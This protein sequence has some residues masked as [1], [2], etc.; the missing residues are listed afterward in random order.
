MDAI[1]AFVN[2]GPDIGDVV[3]PNLLLASSDR[4][5][6][7]AIGVAILRSYGSTDDVMRGQIFDLDQIKRAAEIGVGVDSA[8]KIN[9][10][11]VNDDAIN[12]VDEIRQILTS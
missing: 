9:L 2:R 4:V 12:V 6:M 7:D 5:A 8:D 1:K 10:I 11:P 3:N